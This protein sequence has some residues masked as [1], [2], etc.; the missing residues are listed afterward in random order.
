MD[1]KVCL[2]KNP[3]WQGGMSY[4]KYTFDF[5]PKLKRYIKHRDGRCM[6]CNT[7]IL[8]LKV[9]K[10]PVCIHHID[11]KKENSFPQN[12]ITLCL[13]CHVATNMNRQHWTV[14]FQSMLKEQ[15]GYQYTEDQKIIID[16]DKVIK[17]GIC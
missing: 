14:F 2:E 8:D 12:L 1:G 17:N 5:N 3:N 9:L 7:N 11:Y 4:R 6:V 10:R 15:Y 13:K 16:F